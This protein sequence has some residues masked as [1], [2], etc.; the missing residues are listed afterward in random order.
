MPKRKTNEEFIKEL[1]EKLPKVIP[2]EK[3]SNNHT[4]IVHLFLNDFFFSFL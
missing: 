1:K 3:Y 4:K 2:L